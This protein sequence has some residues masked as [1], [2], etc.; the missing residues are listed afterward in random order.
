MAPDPVIKLE[1]VSWV[2]DGKAILKEIDWTVNPGEHWPWS[3]RT[4]RQTSLLNI[5][6]QCAA[7]FSRRC[8]GGNRRLR[9]AGAAQIYRLSRRPCGS[10]LLG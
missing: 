2:R 7:V 8:F 5:A 4:V 1:K 10:S 3:A 9:P 6:A